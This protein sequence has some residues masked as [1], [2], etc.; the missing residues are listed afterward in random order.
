[1]EELGISMLLFLVAVGV[2]AAF[3]DAVVGGGGLI[4]IPALL[5]A[6]L[7]PAMVLGTNKLAGTMCSFTSTVAFMKSGKVNKRLA[8]ALFPLAFVGSLFGAYTVQHISSDFL[9]PLMLVLLVGVTLFT[10]FKKNW[11]EQST[12][13]GLS[14][15]KWVLCGVV[16]VAIGYYDGFFGPGTGSFLIFA[17]LTLGLDFVT[18]AG[19]AKV[20]NFASNISGLL[21]F[22]YLG[23]VNYT[24]GIVMGLA[25]IVGALI[26]SHFAM[27]KGVGYVKTLFIVVSLL[28][29]GKNAL[30]Y[31]EIL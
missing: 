26:G 10:I 16:V 8:F 30:D 15:R 28:L 31:F 11:G 4:A 21:M 9:K 14:K 19:N 25:M 13:N 6:G 1:M 18:A 27:K 22:M 12:Y 20:L 29:I 17:F 23:S 5:F 7:P 3:V 24:Y 2:L